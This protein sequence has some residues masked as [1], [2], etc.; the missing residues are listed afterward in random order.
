[1]VAASGFIGITFNHRFH[2]WENLNQPQG[3]VADLIIHVRDHADSLGIDRDRI[4]VWAFSGG[5]PFLSGFLRDRPAYL[6]CIVSYYAVMDLP[7]TLRE[8]SP[9]YHVGRAGSG[10]PP[11]FIARAGLDGPEINAGLDRFVQAA[12]SKN[13]TIDLSNHS[14]GHHGFDIYDDNERSRQII[15]RTV[16][17]IK[18]HP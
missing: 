4:V 11:I 9:V 5:G 3:D 1:L 2:S 10:T 13:V 12:L 16:E 8:H 15:K 17:F 14:E 6:R 7:E 18:A